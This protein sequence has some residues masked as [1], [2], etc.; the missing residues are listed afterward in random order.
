MNSKLKGCDY[1][2][3]TIK[4]DWFSNIRVDLLSSFVVG[5]SMI[6][7][8]AGFAIMVG[9]SPMVAFYTTFCMSIVLAFC[10]ARKAM[11]SAAAGSMALVLVVVAK[12]YGVEYIGLVTIA[13]GII[14]ILFGI[15]KIGNLLRFV[16]KSV[17]YGF[18]NSLGIMLFVDQ[19]HF[20]KGQSYIMY[21][22]VLIGLAVIYLFPLITKKIPQNLMAI[23][24]VT[25]IV[26][27][28]HIN[29]PNLGTLGNISATL[30]SFIIPKIS[31][32]FKTLSIVIPYAFS[33]AIVGSVESLL[34]AQSLDE[35]I[36]DKSNKNKEAMA[37]GIGNVVTGFFSGMAGCA[38]IGQSTINSKSGA[39]TRLSTLFAGVS[40]M[41]LVSVFSSY[42]SKIPIA[43]LVSVMIMISITTFSI[44]SVKK[45][46]KTPIID[47]IVMIITVITVLI[48]Q[49][50]AIGVILGVIINALVFVY[51]VAKIDIEKIENEKEV[52][53]KI[54]GYLF[55]AT[56]KKFL[57]SF[58]EDD[59]QKSIVL[60]IT[61]LK[62][63]DNVAKQTM[64]EIKNK[65]KNIIIKEEQN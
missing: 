27:I 48:T 15:F 22:L 10:G 5:L 28:F 52:L 59:L 61:K 23:I 19:L 49:N 47:T 60:D 14:Q 44:E 9:L 2:L 43:A 24:V 7:E 34:T 18:V 6:P 1:L 42:V 33:L 16:P 38:L 30:P 3:E 65:F 41:I 11:I 39:K 64:Y 46:H 8:T 56:S 55:F 37:Q 25:F 13:T 12:K 45:I 54:S 51:R 26:V 35:I 32:N 58:D 57:D 20:F 17:M 21:I 36:G 50:L 63:M 62:L 40:L 53:Y 29:V 4:R 31:I